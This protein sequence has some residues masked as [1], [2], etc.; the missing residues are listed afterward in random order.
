MGSL[1][2]NHTGTVTLPELRSII[3]ERLDITNESEIQR[4]F[5]ALDDNRD[6]EIHYS[7]FL[8]AMLGTMID[9]EDHSLKSAFRAFD[10][11]GSGC[12]TAGSLL[13]VLGNT[14]ERHAHAYI[15]EADPQNRGCICFADFS[16]FLRSTSPTLVTDS[17]PKYDISRE[18]LCGTS[19]LLRARLTNLVFAMHLLFFL[20]R[21]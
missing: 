14:D 12:I 7:D 15:Q 1:D 8:A 9:I 11:D 13:D 5:D 19:R 6:G 10:K 18:I 20:L 16:D 4:I 21:S 17:G 2:T 3:A